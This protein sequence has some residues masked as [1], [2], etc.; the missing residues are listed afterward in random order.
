M[1][2]YLLRTYLMGIIDPLGNEGNN[3]DSFA[4]LHFTMQYV[5]RR[6]YQIR[7]N[8]LSANTFKRGSL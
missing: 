8:Y 7:S 3:V 1:E 6:V 2:D 5:L 4:Y